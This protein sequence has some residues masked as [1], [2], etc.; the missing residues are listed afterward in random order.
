MTIQELISKRFISVE[1][2]EIIDE[3]SDYLNER[4]GNSGTGKG[5]L[6]TI[7]RNNDGERGEEVGEVVVA[8]YAE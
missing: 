2:F 3:H 8:P 5:T 4:C 7:Y 1:E 6:Y